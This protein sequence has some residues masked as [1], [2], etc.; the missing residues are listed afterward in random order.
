M[1]R[2]QTLDLGFD[3]DAMKQMADSDPDR[4]EAVRAEMI[5]SLIDMAPE[6]TRRRLQGVQFKVDS[7]RRI[8]K[9]PLGVC[10]KLSKMMWHSVNELSDTITGNPLAQLEHRGRDN[11]VFVSRWRG[12]LT[13]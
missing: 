12:P 4:F 5:Q 3:F 1:N 10:V 7:I 9:T 11:V 6:E 8:T 13:S 2:W